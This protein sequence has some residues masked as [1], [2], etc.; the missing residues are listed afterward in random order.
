MTGVEAAVCSVLQYPDL[1][2]FGNTTDFMRFLVTPGTDGV[3]GK[4]SRARVQ[5]AP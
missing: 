4:L 1:G 2:V 3:S 5:G